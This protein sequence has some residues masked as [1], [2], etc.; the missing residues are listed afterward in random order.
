[1]RKVIVFLVLIM[2][3]VYVYSADLVATATIPEAKATAFLENFCTMYPNV[4]VDGEGAAK[5]TDE[6]WW[7]E[8]IRRQ[9]V[10]QDYRGAKKK[11]R[12]EAD[13]NVTKDDE[14]LNVTSLGGAVYAGG[15]D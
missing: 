13:A 1:M 10:S 9:T 6:E 2:V 4:E 14:L 15:M 12:T 3:S 7:K 11:A 5:Y 8:C